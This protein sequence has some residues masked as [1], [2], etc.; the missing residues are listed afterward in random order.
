MQATGYTVRDYVDAG[1]W[2]RECDPA[3]A[4]A[5]RIAYGDRTL[6]GLGRQFAET[7]P[8][9]FADIARELRAER[10]YGTRRCEDAPCCGCCD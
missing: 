9:Y 7:E 6:E 3:A 4:A 2:V 8:D 1:R 5:Y 10:S